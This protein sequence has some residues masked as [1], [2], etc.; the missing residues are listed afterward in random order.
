MAG[1]G[2]KRRDA[3]EVHCQWKREKLLYKGII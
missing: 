1:T 3:K 2:F